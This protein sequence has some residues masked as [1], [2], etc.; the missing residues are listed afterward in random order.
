[1]ANYLQRIL[2]QPNNQQ[3][4]IQDIIS[5]MARSEADQRVA[6]QPDESTMIKREA[7][8]APALYGQAQP[9]GKDQIKDAMFKLIMK[10][11][12][13]IEQQQPLTAEDV[14]GQFKTGG[15]GKGLQGLLEYADT[16]EVEE[17]IGTFSNNRFTQEQFQQ[18]AENIRAGKAAAAEAEAA[19]IKEAQAAQQEQAADMY[20]EITQQEQEQ[21]KIDLQRQEIEQ[22]QEQFE[23]EFQQSIEN[24]A[25][26]ASEIKP[27][28]SEASK[29]LGNVT[30]GNDVISSLK[31]INPELILSK[32]KNS[33]RRLQDLQKNMVDVLARMRTGAAISENEE[34]LYASLVPS[35]SDFALGDVNLIDEKLNRFNKLF[36]V[37]SIGLDPEDKYKKL[38]QEKTM[39][40]ES[41]TLPSLPK[42]IAGYKIEEVR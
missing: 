5:Q 39:T 25:K 30:I 2:G 17:A 27:L 38:I 19:A 42:D 15:F 16:G 24:A 41:D 8:Q 3:G 40:Q 20:K 11:A 7:P 21:E 31:S 4:N 28:S 13:P 26:K 23:V 6:L 34:K 22:K 29:M 9:S 10:Q 18:E 14:M 35:L 37:I 1:M 12:Q 33:I 36:N 32:D